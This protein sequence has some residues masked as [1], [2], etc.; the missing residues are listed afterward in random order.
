MTGQVSHDEASRPIGGAN[1]G[2]IS[3]AATPA[4]RRRNG[5]V[6]RSAQASNVSMQPEELT[7]RATFI[8][9]ALALCLAGPVAAGEQVPF[10]GSMSGT[11][12]ITPIGGPIVSVLL[13]TSGTANQLG[14]F[15]LQAPHIVN[16]ATLTAVGTYEFTAPDGSTLT[17]SLS[18]SATMVAPGVLRIAEVGTIT[19]G[20]GRFA[21]ATG[22][23]TTDRTFYPGTG[24]T[25]GSFEGWIST[26]GK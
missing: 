17:A 10:R 11:A 4:Q 24:L 5:L 18:G 7:M 22:T 3:A 8:A 12:T 6:P 21:G 19:G 15:T 16:Q 1:A 25:N 2:A 9:A 14:G 20:T 26:R 23:F 13:E